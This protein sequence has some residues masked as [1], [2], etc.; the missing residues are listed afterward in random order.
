[1]KWKGTKLKNVDSHFNFIDKSDPYL[2]F[3]KVRQDNTFIEVG[4]TEVIE[5]NLQ[6]DWKSVIVPAMKLFNM[7]DPLSSFKVEC[8]D[9]EK[10]VN[11]EKMI[12]ELFIRGE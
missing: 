9:Y 1:M 2:K 7:N 10:N 8:W 12:G 4:R 6:P 3:L 5:D 11:K